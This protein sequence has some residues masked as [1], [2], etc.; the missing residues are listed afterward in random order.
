MMPPKKSNKK[1]MIALVGLVIIVAVAAVFFLTQGSGSADVTCSITSEGMTLSQSYTKKGE[2][3]VSITNSLEQT[4]SEEELESLGMSFDEWYAEN[5]LAFA[6]YD[7]FAGVS[8]VLDKEEDTQTIKIA[9]T[10]DFA[11]YDFETD[12]LGVGAIDNYADT[13]AIA[14]ELESY[15]Y[16]CTGQN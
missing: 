1:M 6:S 5:E 10:I 15:G 11:E 13:D 8:Y 16:T 2:E 3:V 14:T 7:E 9:L 4:I 12:A